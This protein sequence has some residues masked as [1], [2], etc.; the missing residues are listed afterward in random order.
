MSY[1]PPGPPPITATSN[2]SDEKYLRGLKE[3]AFP[4]VD[5]ECRFISFVQRCNMVQIVLTYLSC[6]EFWY[7]KTPEKI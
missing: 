6:E 3:S 2:C 4:Y 5:N 7:S 1:I